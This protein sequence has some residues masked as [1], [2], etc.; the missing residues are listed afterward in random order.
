MQPVPKT[1]AVFAVDDFCISIS[2]S[3]FRSFFRRSIFM[4]FLIWLSNTTAI[5]SRGH[6]ILCQTCQRGVKL[7]PHIFR[8]CTFEPNSSCLDLMVN[9]LI[10]AELF[11]LKIKENS[12]FPEKRYNQNGF[13]FD[14]SKVI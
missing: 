4:I 3:T 7:F 2:S 6:V 12:I 5:C 1:P 11:I 8:S 10:L 14:F 9:H 13:D